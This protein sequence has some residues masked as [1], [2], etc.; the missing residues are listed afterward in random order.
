MGRHGRLIAGAMPALPARNEEWIAMAK[1]VMWWDKRVEHSDELVL[2]GSVS[3]IPQRAILAL[4][5]KLEPKGEDRRRPQLG[6]FWPASKIGHV[7]FPSDYCLLMKGSTGEL[8]DALTKD[9]D[10][11]IKALAVIG[12][13]AL[14]VQ[15]FRTKESTGLALT[16][17]VSVIGIG[18]KTKYWGAD[19]VVNLT[20]SQA[21]A[22]KNWAWAHMGTFGRSNPTYH[23]DHPTGVAYAAIKLTS[24]IDLL[25]MGEGE[26]AWF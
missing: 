24:L 23:P 8:C 14:M 22:N 18:S 21:R 15:F 17:T 13:M 19:N 10:S 12:E 4:D 26:E 7:E 16:K 3:G 11:G 1:A 5:G 9:M 6:Y 2:K 20:V 25:K